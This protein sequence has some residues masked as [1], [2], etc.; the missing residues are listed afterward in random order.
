MQES[1]SKVE[2][3]SARRKEIQSLRSELL[4]AKQD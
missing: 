3:V 1:E 4:K 2:L